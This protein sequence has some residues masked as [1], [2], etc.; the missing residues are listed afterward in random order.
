[1]LAADLN[2]AQNVGFG[3]IAAFMIVFAVNV[4]RSIDPVL[5][6]GFGHR[7]TRWKAACGQGEPTVRFAALCRA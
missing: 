3:I 5:P 1:M 6:S 2:V 7:R 4:V